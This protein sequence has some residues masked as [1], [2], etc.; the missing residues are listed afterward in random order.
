LRQNSIDPWSMT[1]LTV[2]HVTETRV[3]EES[4]FVR[5][6]HTEISS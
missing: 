4:S 2:S 6:P 1:L 5:A 3:L